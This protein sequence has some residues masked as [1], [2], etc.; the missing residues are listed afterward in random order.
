MAEGKR[1]TMARIVEPGTREAWEAMR[2]PFAEGGLQGI[3]TSE[4]AAALGHSPYKTPLELWQEKTGLRPRGADNEA[5]QRGRDNEAETRAWFAMNH[6]EFRVDYHATRY[7]VSEE[8]PLFTT[9]DGE[10]E[11]LEDAEL[12]VTDPRTGVHAVMSL[13]KGMH[14]ILE[15]KDTMPRTE[16]AYAG[17]S[18]WPEMYVWQNAGQLRVTG[19]DFTVDVA[20]IT[21]DYARKGGEYRIYGAFAEE[22]AS[23][24]QEIA[25]RLPSFW[26]SVRTKTQPG[27]RLFDAESLSLVELK[28]EM[29]PGTI[30]ADFD[31]AKAGVQRYAA[32]FK[33]LTFSESQLKEA[34]KAR[35]ELNRYKKALNDTRIAISRQYD[36]PLSEFK[37]CVDELIGIVDAV[38][39]P[40]DRQI[41]DAEKALDEAKLAKAREVVKA[42]LE[43]EESAD[44]RSAI[45]AMGGVIE[46]PKW[47]NA[48]VKL[49]DI[50]AE[51]KGFIASVKSDLAS[52]SAIADDEQMHQALL[53]EYFR[54][55]NLNE[56]ISAKE[57]ILAARKASAEAAEERKRQ[58][59][60]VKAMRQG[61]QEDPPEHLKADE[62][63]VQVQGGCESAAAE[64]RKEICLTLRF[65][66][67]DPEAFK[68]LLAYMKQNGFTYEMVGR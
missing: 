60:A 16:E 45:E 4:L 1:K 22:F 23:E 62:R 5:M 57:R 66:H 52:I 58:A 18:R 34:K 29:K 51:V 21:G 20:H 17:W 53:Q 48:S 35:A 49:K 12:H 68:A 37:D 25:D 26:E 65:H 46:N 7:Y 63:P 19:F 15:I 67:T 13:R 27:T 61:W 54:T 28:P 6:R 31:D 41:K 2:D 59:E 56:A 64:E 40:I 39:V 24:H 55:R 30:W 42:C 47:M 38:C 14:G 36:M 50:E 11:V 3:G 43:A 8:L 32:R 9:L 33:G 10:L 44:A